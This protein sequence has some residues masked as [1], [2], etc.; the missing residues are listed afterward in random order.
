MNRPTSL[1][2]ALITIVTLVCLPIGAVQVQTQAADETGYSWHR[3]V[4]G[5]GKGSLGP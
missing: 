2:A 5:R 3:R 1:H 4:A